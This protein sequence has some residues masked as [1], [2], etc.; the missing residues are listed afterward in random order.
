MKNNKKKLRNLGCMLLLSCS[1]LQAEAA[2]TLRFGFA[3]SDSDTQ[4]LAARSSRNGSRTV[5][6]ASC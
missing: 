1:M 3:G 4:S 5:P 6:M 2:T